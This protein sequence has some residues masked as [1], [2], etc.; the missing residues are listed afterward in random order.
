[1]ED[2]QREG[3]ITVDGNKKKRGSSEDDR[4]EGEDSGIAK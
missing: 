1:V 2:R 3:D 4:H